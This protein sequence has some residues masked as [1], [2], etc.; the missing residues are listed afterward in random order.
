[1]T[2]LPDSG[3]DAIEIL[4]AEPLGAEED[5]LV[6]AIDPVDLI[7]RRAKNE[8]P[9]DRIA[10]LERQLRDETD[11]SRA[12]VLQHEIA[13]LNERTA[14]EETDVAQGYAAALA[15]DPA[16]RP[17]LWALRRLYYRRGLWPSLL[18]LLD[19]EADSAASARERAEL[20]TEKGHVL[21]DRLG[22]VSEAVSCYRTA[23]ELDQEALAPLVALEKVLTRQSGQSVLAG[24]TIRPSD[25]LMAVYRALATATKDPSRR[26]ALLIEQA[27][28]EEVP[29]VKLDDK[30]GPPPDVTPVLNYLHDAYD[31]GVDQLRVIDE[32]VRITAAAGRIPD[33]LTALEIRAE[34]LEMQAENAT[35]QRK[36][37]LSDQVVGIRRWQAS[38]ARQRAGNLEL[39]CQYLEKAQEKS[40]GDPLL[41]PELLSVADALGNPE[42][43]LQLLVERE[44]ELRIQR[45]DDA[46]PPVGLWLKQAV[47]LRQA[48]RDAEAEQTEA[49]ITEASPTHLLLQLL[50]QRRAM[51]RQDLP[52]LTKLLQLEAEQADRGL[53]NS[54]GQLVRDP[55]WAC[56]ALIA[57]ADCALQSG[58]LTQAET[59]AQR[60]EGF[61]SKPVDA[62]G[63]THRRLIDALLEEIY[64]RSSREG[65]LVGLFERRIAEGYASEIETTLLR[66]NLVEL[67][68][69]VLGTPESAAPH[70][71]ALRKQSSSD[72]R[73]LRRQVLLARQRGDV[74]GE[75]AALLQWIA[76]ASAK[77]HTLVEDLLRRAELLVK[78]GRQ[79]E[80]GALYEQVLAQQPGH[81]QAL[82][83]LE[84]VYLT[85][86]KKDELSQ[87]LR[88]Q[89]ELVSHTTADDPDGLSAERAL[90]AKLIDLI[91]NELNLPDQAAS[92]Y[93]AMLQRDPGYLPAL[94]ALLSH[95]RRTGETAKLTATLH[96]IA[97]HAPTSLLRGDA[98][99]KLAELRE[100][101]ASQ[102]PQEADELYEQ[103]L[104]A[105]PMPSAQATHAAVGRLRTT[106]QQRKYDKLP[107]VLEALADSLPG[108]DPLTAEAVALLAEER[109]SLLLLSATPTNT[110]MERADAQLAKASKD[111]RLQPVKHTETLVQLATTRVL[112]NQRREDGKAQSAALLELAELMLSH[113]DVGS[114]VVAGELLLRSGLLAALYDDDPGQ[115]T[116]AARRLLLA[117]RTLGDQP[118]VVIPLTDLLSDP[119]VLEQMAQIPDVVKVLRARQA[120]CPDTEASDRVAF[121]LL[122]AEAF[123][124]QS[125]ADEVDDQTAAKLRLSAAEA[126]LRALHLDP[127]NLQ[128]LLLLRQATAPSDSEINPLRA[129]PLSPEGAVRL[130]A[131]A[132]YTLKLAAQLGEGEART[133]LYTEAGQLFLQLGDQ[134]GAAAVLRTALDGRPFDDNIFTALLTLLQRRAEQTGDHGPLLE[135]LDFRLSQVARSDEERRQ[136][137]PVRTALLSQRAALHLLTGQNVAAAGDLETLLSLAPDHA[138]S[139]QR[140]ATLRTQHGDLAA[141]ALHYQRLLELST[142]KAEKLAIHRSLGELLSETTTE[143][144]IVH[145][146]EALRLG[147]ELRVEG[148]NSETTDEVEQRVQLQK[149][150]LGLQLRRGDRDAATQAVKL[151]VS[152]LPTGKDLASLRQLVLLEAAGLYE[153][154]LGD[155]TA[156]LAVL[157]KLL[158]E[159]PLQL[160]AIER[161]VTLSQGSGETARPQAMLVRARDEARKQAAAFA[162]VDTALSIVPFATLQQVF[163][164]QKQSDA[165]SLAGQATAVVTKFLG[166]SAESPL[167]PPMKIPDRSVG[168]PLR[169]AAFSTDARGILLDIWQEVWE[170]GTKLLSPD[171]ATLSTNPR[172]RL[173]AKKVPPTWASVDNLAQR[174][175]LGNTDLSI[176]YSL[177]AGK[178]KEGCVAVGPNLVCGSAYTESLASWSPLLLFRLVR[179]LALVPDRLGAIDCPPT[180]LLLFVAACCQLVS[181]PTPALAGP[182]RSKLDERV[183]NLDRAIARKER[184]ALKGLASRMHEL[185]GE[186]GKSLVLGWQRA[187]LRGSA[188]LAT[189]ITGNLSAALQESGAKL[190]TDDEHEAKTARALLTW[191]VSA[192]LLGLRR[193]LGLSEKE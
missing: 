76:T 67:Y 137:L 186:N 178:D 107:D 172:D 27:R 114:K 144:S 37:L 133:D 49:R 40:P 10:A 94:S 99:V 110:A 183:R 184:S 171:L 118:Q 24:T 23:H 95:Q 119:T 161:V 152:E 193:E 20:L 153:R 158:A 117:Y 130:R 53:A 52:G 111:L 6:G 45:P 18:Q 79:P 101:S 105:L 103:A 98:L 151:L 113:E 157:D 78:L 50:R 146:G 2:L 126:T 56:E 33:C 5:R 141:A 81:P 73:L 162:D 7:K 59:L 177:I 90:H 11:P 70:K 168:P 135:L 29:R 189:A 12:A 112:L 58:D 22:H 46:P 187:I 3:A 51:Q 82:E 28:I 72:L 122:E 163:E 91:E 134:D 57:A 159:Q 16:L 15:L 8:R 1:M 140:L 85:Q 19:I 131:Y 60:A 74:A 100:E 129:E 54:D 92:L 169:S 13:V 48:S 182:E 143:H 167:P 149:R 63:L 127:H 185:S 41:G 35:P 123:L 145:F 47:A 75:E 83:E 30:D 89:I 174:F 160:A 42:K 43:L 181:I 17:N 55:A 120:L 97:E 124:I 121:I 61:L 165:R 139:H 106:M 166:G 36:Q 64:L 148:G 132:M 116:E 190:E 109:A 69:G 142:G 102:K 156:A 86:G 77:G 138:L 21:E 4:D 84:R 32:I 191:S 88:R 31:V 25:E 14:D 150:L 38:L 164:W 125:S 71:E 87:L 68:A 62:A 104:Q 44:R 93:K 176:A 147:A 179:R 175:G 65:L 180:E 154:D 66:E 34:I 39:A 136:D 9:R 108:D 155:R 80:A 128:A 173:N 192:E 96:Q 26:V 170:T 115:L 188:L